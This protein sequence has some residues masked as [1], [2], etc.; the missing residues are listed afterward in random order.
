[1]YKFVAL[2][3]LLIRNFYLPNP[4]ESLEY[5]III[6]WMI[7]PVLFSITFGVVGLFYRRGFAP[8]WGSFL[9][10]F[11]YA[12]HTYLIMLCS[13]FGFTE[14]AISTILILYIA[15]LAELIKLKNKLVSSNYY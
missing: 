14:I 7:E 3:S 4:F 13:N 1:M 2:V 15:I 8:A 12:L 5:G 11:F 10:L 9:Y 6:N